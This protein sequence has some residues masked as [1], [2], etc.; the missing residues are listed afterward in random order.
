MKPVLILMVVILSGC[1][2]DFKK[3]DIV[4][5]DI[6]CGYWIGYAQNKHIV[7][8]HKTGNIILVH[9]FYHPL[10]GVESCEH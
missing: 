7:K 8:E 4:A 1:T 5:T 10:I 9:Q 6:V 3:G 2:P